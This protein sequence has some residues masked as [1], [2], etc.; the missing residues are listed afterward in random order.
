MQNTEVLTKYARLVLEKGVN[1]QQDQAVVVSAPIEGADFVRILAKEAYAL[2]A[3]NV[4]INWGD[5]E[6]TR[7]KYEHASD[8]VMD[9][10]PSWRV[11]MMEDF[12]E[13]GAAFVS[14]HATDPDLLQGIDS[15]RVARASKASGVALKTFRE[16]TMNDRVTWS[17]ISIPTEAWAEKIFPNKTTEEAVQAL[18]DEIIKMVRV[19][20]PDVIQAWDEHNKRLETAYKILNEKQ[21]AALRLRAPG[22]DIEVGL[23]KNHV[24]QGGAAVSEK[25]TVFNPN[26]PTEEVFTAPHKYKVNGTVSSTKP[27][28]YGGNLI[29]EFQLTFKDGKVTDYQAKQGEEVLAHLLDSDEGARRIGEMA[30]VPDESP[31]SQSGL[32]FYNTLFDENASC[33]IALGKAYP[34]NVQGGAD[35]DEA[36]LDEHG[37]NDS[38][39][40]VDFMVGSAE[41]DIDG[42]LEDGTE[43]A[44]FRNGTWAFEL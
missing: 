3:K 29:D 16:Y 2:G 40:H 10:F 39:I 17:V 34:T 12:A 13:D 21:Y 25:G 42:V 15:E 8:E 19:D 5:D 27:L 11:Q 4:H 37:V 20:Q 1:V 31:V 44:V 18:W 36:T 22:T 41:M 26:L 33:H 23:A 6:L 14:I 7:L 35:M 43:E 24:W 9:H 28:N 38:M 30:L 32:I